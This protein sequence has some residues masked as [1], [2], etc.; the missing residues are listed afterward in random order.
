V[1][2]KHLVG[3]PVTFF[4]RVASDIRILSVYLVNVSQVFPMNHNKCDMSIWS[5]CGPSKHGEADVSVSLHFLGW[6]FPI[7]SWVEGP[8]VRQIKFQDLA[9]CTPPQALI[10]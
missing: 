1:E 10:S 3:D 9:T 2:S 4:V 6:R 5:V 8:Q 7:L